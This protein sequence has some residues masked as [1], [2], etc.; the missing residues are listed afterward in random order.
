MFRRDR[1]AASLRCRASASRRSFC[2]ICSLSSSAYSLFR[3][4]RSYSSDRTSPW[5]MNFIPVR[6]GSRR[7]LEP[8]KYEWN[9]R[10]AGP[11][12]PGDSRP[13]S[14]SSPP[15]PPP[16]DPGWCVSHCLCSSTIPAPA[17]SA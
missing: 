14:S 15:E 13:S 4:R 1:D 9:R 16:E 8:P 6:A 17:L 7:P 3:L 12:P 5:C 11:F 2:S 10:T